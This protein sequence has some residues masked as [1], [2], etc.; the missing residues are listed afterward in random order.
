MFLAAHKREQILPQ[1]VVLISTKDENEIC[2]IAPWSNITSILRPL[3]EIVL[4]SWIKRDTLENIRETQEFV[5]NIPSTNMIEEVMTCSK[6]YPPQVD[7]FECSKLKVHASKEI[8]APGIEGCLAWAE[9]KLVEEIKR[10]KYSLII[11][12]VVSLEVNDNFFNEDGDMDYEK[13]KPL[14]I[15]L[16]NKGMWFT[17]PVFTGKYNKYSEMFIEQKDKDPNL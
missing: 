14:S 1:P 3:D 17:H 4:A 5:V 7:E 16:G 6:N 15:M 10:E 2:N 12:K 9:C 13:A 8:K 11:G